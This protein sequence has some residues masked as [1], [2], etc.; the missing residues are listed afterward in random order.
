MFTV[1]FAESERNDTKT[2]ITFITS[3]TS[4]FRFPLYLPAVFVVTSV[5]K[6]F[7]AVYNAETLLLTSMHTRIS[8]MAD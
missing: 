2:F 4:M 5:M 6:K 7:A 8:K 3:W 1:C